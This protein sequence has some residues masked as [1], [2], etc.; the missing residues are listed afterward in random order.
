MEEF[1]SQ[2]EAILK[3]ELTNAHREHNGRNGEGLFG[4][5]QK[6][7]RRHKLEVHH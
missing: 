3:S 2:A 5:S 7:R 4:T 1:R 6:A